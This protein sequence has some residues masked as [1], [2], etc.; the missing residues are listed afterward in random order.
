MRFH[1]KCSLSNPVCVTVFCSPGQLV[2]PRF[3][4]FCRKVLAFG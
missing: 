1:M 2:L 3:S 4:W